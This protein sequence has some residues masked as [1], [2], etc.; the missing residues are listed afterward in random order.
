MSQESESADGGDFNREGDL[1]ILA[2]NGTWQIVKPYKDLL[3]KNLFTLQTNLTILSTRD[4]N[5]KPYHRHHQIL[6]KS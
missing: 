4:Y 6:P 3:L 2:I 1:L 5:R